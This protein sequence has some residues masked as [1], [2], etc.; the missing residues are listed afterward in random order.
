MTTGASR[1]ADLRLGEGG[2]AFD[3][4]TGDT[5]TLSATGIELVAWL[6]DGCRSGD[7]VERLCVRYAIT[8]QAAQRDVEDFL[9][10]LRGWR[11]L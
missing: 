10:T 11:L 8:P 7:L 4:R 5:Y 6:R 3:P 2:F 9:A 1:L